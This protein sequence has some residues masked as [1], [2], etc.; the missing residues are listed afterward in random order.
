[1]VSWYI[2]VI[3]RLGLGSPSSAQMVM[4]ERILERE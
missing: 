2:L 3:S 1:M 4:L